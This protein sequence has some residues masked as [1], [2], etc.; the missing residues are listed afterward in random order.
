MWVICLYCDNSWDKEA[1]E[2]VLKVCYKLGCAPDQYKVSF[3]GD[4][5]Q[6]QLSDSVTLLRRTPTC[7]EPS[8]LVLCL[9]ADSFRL[10]D[11]S[12][13]IWRQRVRAQRLPLECQSVPSPCPEL[14]VLT[15]I[16]GDFF[17]KP[18]I[19]ELVDGL[20]K[21][22][23]VKRKTLE[24]E[25]EDAVGAQFDPVSEDEDESPA[26]KKARLV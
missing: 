16:A 23:T 14:S 15:T 22:K 11:D 4:A 17:E 8:L 24:Q 2:Q 21:A 3:S 18:E 13:A 1:V 6:T 26:G 10:A 25:Q 12:R 9:L 20:A 7:G 5:V 19:D